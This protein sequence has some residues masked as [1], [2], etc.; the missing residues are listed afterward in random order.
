MSLFDYSERLDRL[1]HI[2]QE[3]HADAVAMVPGANMVYFTGLHYHLMERPTIALALSGGGMAF[4]LPELEYTKL[5]PRMEELDV[6]ELF[7][8]SDK[9]GYA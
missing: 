1:R 8:W 5:Q 4:I 9:A 7:L 3:R 2:A 6:R